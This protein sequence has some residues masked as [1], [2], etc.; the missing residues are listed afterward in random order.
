M[1]NNPLDHCLKKKTLARHIGTKKIFY[2][3]HV[4]YIITENQEIGR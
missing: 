2:H 1:V 3:Y 4:R